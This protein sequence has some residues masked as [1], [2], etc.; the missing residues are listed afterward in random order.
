MAKYYEKEHVDAYARIRSE[1]LD[2]WDDLHAEDAD[3]GYENFANRPF[4]ER[5]LPLIGAGSTVFEYGCGTGGAACFL[6]E[7]GFRVTAV[8]L[9][10]DAIAVARSRAA[11]R[12]LGIHF[13]VGDICT[14]GT[15]EGTFDVVVDCYCLQSIVTDHDRDTVLRRMTEMLAPRGRFLLSTAMFRPERDYGDHLYDEDTGIAWA[16]TTTPDEESREFNGTW[17]CPNRR[18]LTAGALRTELERH[19]LEILEQSGPGGGDVV[20]R[21]RGA[22]VRRA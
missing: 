9:V 21:L 15:P 16:P 4:L 18:H 8:D 10:P 11:E 22:T 1:G 14:D 20:C 6:A 5:C 12:G 19:G 17:Y 3:R 13:E 2:Q 7:R